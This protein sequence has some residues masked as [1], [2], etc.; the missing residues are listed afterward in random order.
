MS[1]NFSDDDY[2]DEPGFLRRR[3]LL[4]AGVLVLGAAAGGWYALSS[5]DS[6]PV[7]KAPENT[8]VRIEVPP[9]PPPPPPP[10]KPEPEPEEVKEEEVEEEMI[11]QEEVTEADE[12]PPEEAPPSDEPPSEPL[13][14]AIAGDGPGDGFGLGVGGGL[15]GGGRGGIGGGGK[16][17]SRFGWYA[18][19]V[20]KTVASTLRANKQ[21]RAATFSGQ[22]S[23]WADASG[24]I[25]RA[26]MKGNTGPIDIS[27]VLRGV[28]LQEPPPADMPMPIHMRVSARQPQ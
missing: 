23:I 13:G 25:T 10:P 8:F 15:G 17:G 5:G 27:E 16:G 12:A 7:R 18:S 2:D 6:K 1:T 20:Q 11:A 21:T 22:L 4:I 14:T 24:T 26:Q 28:R 3:G 9:P 19:Q